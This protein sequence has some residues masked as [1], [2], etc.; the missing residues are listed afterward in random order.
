MTE[1]KALVPHQQSA[2][3]VYGSGED[4]KALS[5]RIKFCLPGGNRLQDHEALSLAQLSVAYGLNPFNGEVWYLPG[6]GTMVGIKG[7]RKA[8]RKQSHYFPTF[9]LLTQQEKKDLAIPDNAIAYRCLISRTD[10][11]L[12][13]AHAVDI[14]SKAGMKNAFEVYAYK[15]AEGI[16]YAVPGESTKMKLDQSARK[17]SEAE[18]LKVSFDLP[19]ANELGGDDRVGFVDAEWY[20]VQQEPKFTGEKLQE[21]L[22]ENVEL[23]RGSEDG[24]GIGDDEPDLDDVFNEEPIPDFPHEP[25]G[26]FGAV[27]KVTNYKYKNLKHLTE[28]FKR[29]LNMTK[30]PKKEDNVAWNDLLRCATGEDL[31]F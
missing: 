10:L 28:K 6:K 26:F 21:R 27:N 29:E 8:A 1:E 11:L 20:D 24:P 17:R 3:D 14:I 4:I 22:K 2:L 16:G 18:A 15:P 12:E 5:Q 13:V 31:P 25:M 7:L 23:L 9:T 30:W 19:F